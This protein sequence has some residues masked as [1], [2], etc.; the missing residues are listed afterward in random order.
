MASKKEE[1]VYGRLSDL[2]DHEPNIY[3]LTRNLA[4]IAKQIKQDTREDTSAP[5]PIPEAIERLYNNRI[6]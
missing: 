1:T 4:R 2:T 3:E 5:K 6:A